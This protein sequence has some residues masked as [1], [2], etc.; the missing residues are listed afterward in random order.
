[1]TSYSGTRDPYE[2]RGSKSITSEGTQLCTQIKRV[3][4]F[5]D[6]LFQKL[7]TYVFHTL[8][9]YTTV[10]S[11]DMQVFNQSTYFFNIMRNGFK[12]SKL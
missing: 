4:A 8:L 10:N 3:C 1:M 11:E 2:S 7:N 5:L 6:S 9:P 12:Q